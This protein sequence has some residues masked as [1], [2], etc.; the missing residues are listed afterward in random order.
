MHKLEQI[1]DGIRKT[2]DARTSARDLALAQARQLTRAC[3]LAIRAVHR[4][5]A[6]VMN[7]HLQEARQLADTLRNSLASYPDQILITADTRDKLAAI[8]KQAGIFVQD[9]APAA[10]EGQPLPSVAIAGRL[11]EFE[12][13]KK[14]LE[15]FKT[16]NIDAVIV[17]LQLPNKDG[18]ALTEEI[19]KQPAG[20]Y[21]PLLG[22]SSD[23]P[24]RDDAHPLPAG[25]LASVHKPIRPVQLLDA[26]CQIACLTKR[27]TVQQ[28]GLD[29][30]RMPGDIAEHR[31][32]GTVGA[33]G[34]LERVADRLRV[35]LGTE[36]VIG[37]AGEV[38]TLVHMVFQPL[39]Q[40]AVQVAPQRRWH[41]RFQ[42]VSDQIVTTG[43]VT[44]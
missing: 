40:P 5:E 42:A 32:S 17:D 3:S 33:L 13:V 36:T 21:V 23:R 27:T 24:G 1:T 6:D 26:L 31:E 34:R 29:D 4:D 22:L 10:L 11:G 20:H 37:K 28:T 14:L 44:V 18:S 43:H 7:A 16:E 38:G 25:I 15:K 30:A 35:V 2:F 41:C 19:R 9:D 8:A 39:Q 12:D